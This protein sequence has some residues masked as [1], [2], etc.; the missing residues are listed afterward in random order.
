MMDIDTLLN[1][2][3]GL[4]Q[5]K[6]QR[7]PAGLELTLKAVYR[8]EGSGAMDFGGSEYRAAG[9]C[10]LG[11]VKGP[12]DKYGWWHL[13]SGL[14]RL[15]FNESVSLQAA[16][17]ALITPHPRLLQAGG[18]HDGVVFGPGEPLTAILQVLVS[19]LSLKENCRMSRLNVL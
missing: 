1:R 6:T 16:E 18:R 10:R 12:T 8:L 13:G 19:R 15:E 7:G 5:E 9:A 2:A 11:C 17:R 14:Y 4:V 3:C